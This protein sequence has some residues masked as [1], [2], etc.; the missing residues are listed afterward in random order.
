MEPRRSPRLRDASTHVAAHRQPRAKEAS[1]PSRWELL[2]RTNVPPKFAR[3]TTWLYSISPAAYVIGGI[4][5]SSRPHAAGFDRWVWVL[6]AVLCY[7]SD[8]HTLGLDSAWHLADRWFAPSLGCFRVAFSLYEWRVLHTFYDGQ[9]L[10]LY[11]GL[12]V[13]LGAK[14]FGTVARR[15][16][17]CATYMWAHTIWHIAVPA[18]MVAMNCLFE[19][20]P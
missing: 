5:L 3:R 10:A 19:H 6:Q 18:G 4:A 11:I 1:R 20:P 9:M 8:V 14:L 15:R 13:A 16:N 7:M 12:A 17:D 2:C